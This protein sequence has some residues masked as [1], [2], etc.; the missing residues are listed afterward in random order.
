LNW[1]ITLA[2]KE[3]LTL[4]KIKRYLV[5]A[6]SIETFVAITIEPRQAISLKIARVNDP[7]NDKIITLLALIEC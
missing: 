7:L 1:L 5:V 6:A 2:L 4:A 3:A